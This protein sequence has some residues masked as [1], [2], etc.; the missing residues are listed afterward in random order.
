[1]SLD[2]IE[3]TAPSAWASYLIND[4][5]SGLDDQEQAQCDAWVASLAPHTYAIDCAD[6][7][8]RWRHDAHAFCPLGADCQRYTF[9][10]YG[11]VAE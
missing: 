5:A 4:D 7:G 9:A 2:T 1:M 11:S 10:N 8:F 6:A 3:V